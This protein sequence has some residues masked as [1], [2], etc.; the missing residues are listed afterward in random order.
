MASL[1]NWE[2]ATK[3]Y[4]GF[5][6][7]S[8]SKDRHRK[9]SAAGMENRPVASAELWEGGVWK[10]LPTRS[11]EILL[12]RGQRQLCDL[13]RPLPAWPFMSLWLNHVVLMASS[14]PCTGC[15]GMVAAK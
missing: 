11:G 14:C 15:S 7:P 5:G 9:A 2:K 3:K 1:L 12:G 10:E 6:A 4:R 13:D 8:V